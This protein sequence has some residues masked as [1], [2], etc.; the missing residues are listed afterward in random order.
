MPIRGSISNSLRA[1][2]GETNIGDQTP[3]TPSIDYV[4]VAGG[5]P[6]GYGGGGGGGGGGIVYGSGYPVGQG[7]VLTFQV[8]GGG[9][10]STLNGQD[11]N[12]TNTPSVF[13][14][15]GGGGGD[16][17]AGPGNPGNDGGSGGGGGRDTPAPS[18]TSYGLSTQTSPGIGSIKGNRGGRGGNPPQGAAGGGGGSGG[19]G[20][21][22]G[23]SPGQ[24]YDSAKNGGDGD[25][26]QN[27]FGFPDPTTY[28][29]AF[30]ING[31]TPFAGT[32]ENYIVSA[33]GG[34]GIQGEN[35]GQ[36]AGYGGS[37]KS[38]SGYPHTGGDGG[39]APGAPVEANN[40][41]R[42][43]GSGGGGGAHNPGG[44]VSTAGGSGGSGTI[45]V[46]YP[47]S[48]SNA[49]V[50]GAIYVKQGGYRVMHFLGS[51]SIKF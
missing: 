33:G 2:G 25:S 41:T 15:R 28:L 7:T 14:L 23:S 37:S 26:L 35:S 19:Q 3:I 6:G 21:D 27:N 42:Y 48:Y 31:G 30:G 24:P 44:G 43:T 20:Q 11:I 49:S 34:N 45:V 29:N 39:R 17:G 5:G 9:G 47:D 12:G 32:W 38:W 18:T 13:A 10:N 40:A 50:T 36:R 51:G 1:Y 4:V 8:G 46:K 22:G 16:G